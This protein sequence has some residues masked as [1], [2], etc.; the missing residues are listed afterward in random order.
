MNVEKQSLPNRLV[1]VVGG[2]APLKSGIQ[3]VYWSGVGGE[4]DNVVEEVH[5][6]DRVEEHHN[7][8]STLH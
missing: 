4:E 1:I 5:L 7:M 8:W 6:E 3:S 2:P